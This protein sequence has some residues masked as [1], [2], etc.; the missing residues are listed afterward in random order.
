MWAGLERLFL[1]PLRASEG[2]WLACR[3]AVPEAGCKGASPEGEVDG[4]MHCHP[5]ESPPWASFSELNAALF[6]WSGGSRRETEWERKGERERER[7]NVFVCVG[8][9]LVVWVCGYDTVRERERE[10]EN[11][12]QRVW[13]RASLLCALCQCPKTA[14]LSTGAKRPCWQ[15]HLHATETVPLFRHRS[16]NPTF[17]LTS[18]D[19]AQCCQTTVILI[20]HRLT[21]AFQSW[22]WSKK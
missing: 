18:W 16:K 17:N 11:E 20:Q 7:G 2:L 8:C 5:D 19:P 4:G 21:W 3:A 1:A 9:V 15:Q 22:P 10:R 13:V 12:K 6:C 14:H